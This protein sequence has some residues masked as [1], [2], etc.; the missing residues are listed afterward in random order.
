MRLVNECLA[1]IHVSQ[2]VSVASL[3]LMQLVNK[4]SKGFWEGAYIG[5]RVRVNQCIFAH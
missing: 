2:S 3:G 1:G 4:N 5:G